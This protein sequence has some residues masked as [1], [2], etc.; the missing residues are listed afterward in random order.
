MEIL[1]FELPW[2]QGYDKKNGVS[3]N[4]PRLT[5]WFGDLPYSYSGCTL[6]ANNQ[7]RNLVSIYNFKCGL[8]PSGI[9]KY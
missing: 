2:R 6:K 3:Y 7:V 5:A 1:K 4:Q 8:F 9:F